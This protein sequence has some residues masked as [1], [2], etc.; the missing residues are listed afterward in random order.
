VEL[1]SC[2]PNG[3]LILATTPE[4]SG[5]VCLIDYDITAL[6]RLERLSSTDW[7]VRMNS[8]EIDRKRPQTTWHTITEFYEIRKAFLTVLTAKIQIE[9]FWVVTPCGNVIGYQ[10]FGGPCCLHLHW[11]VTPCSVVVGYQR[12]GGPCCLHL[13]WVVTPSCRR[14]PTFRRTL[15]LPSS[16]GCDTV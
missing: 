14:I 15:L 13:H 3:R 2:R 4:L 5:L 11:V 1:L 6:Y 8:Q 16:L 7:E 10:R 9:L 12:F